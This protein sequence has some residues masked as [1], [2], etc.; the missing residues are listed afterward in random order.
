MLTKVSLLGRCLLHRSSLTKLLCQI[1]GV[2][3]SESARLAAERA[4][5]CPFLLLLSFSGSSCPTTSLF[6]CY[7][8]WDEC[9]QDVAAHAPCSSY[10]SPAYIFHQQYIIGQAKDLP[11]RQVW[12]SLPGVR[13]SIWPLR[14]S[15]WAFKSRA[16]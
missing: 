10:F 9:R 13:S 3:G 7:D 11:S 4:N 15:K 16:S 14:C 2:L 6:L 1:P 8:G 5:S 12:V